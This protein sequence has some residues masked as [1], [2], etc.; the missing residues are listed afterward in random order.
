ME[1]KI[2]C[3]E[4]FLLFPQCFLPNQIIVCPFVHIFDVISLFAAELEDPKIGI[5]GKGLILWN[6]II[7]SKFIHI[8]K[9]LNIWR[10]FPLMTSNQTILRKIK[11]AFFSCNASIRAYR[12][13]NIRNT[14]QPKCPTL[15]L[16]LAKTSLE[17][18]SWPKCPYPKRPPFH[19]QGYN[20]SSTPNLQAT[21]RLAQ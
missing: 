6:T 9:T 20:K 19:W 14:I 17:K 7:M 12:V 16:Q 11:N 2:A 15:H 8:N 4:Q 3:N 5:W 1:L 18:M 21:S 13:K 10:Y